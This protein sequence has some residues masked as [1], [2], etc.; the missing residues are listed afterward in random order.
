MDLRGFYDVIKKIAAEIAEDAVV[1]VSRE[2]ADGGRAGVMTEVPR[3]LAA[4]LIAEGK[5]G[6][7]SAEESAKFREAAEA[8][9][10]S[11]DR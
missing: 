4:R 10:K 2:T 6:L 7:A 3:M 9:W 11:G 1:I 5:A 8:R